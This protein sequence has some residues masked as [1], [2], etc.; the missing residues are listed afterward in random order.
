M[1]KS[2]KAEEVIFPGV[3]DIALNHVVVR[4]SKLSTAMILFSKLGYRH[5]GHDMFK[6]P[7]YKS[8]IF[9]AKYG[10]PHV[11][12]V[13]RPTPL[14]ASDESRLVMSVDNP[15]EVVNA[16]FNWSASRG[17]FADVVESTGGGY[18]I[19]LNTLLAMPL[20]FIPYNLISGS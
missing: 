6:K 3:G 15:G 20:E 19:T 8:I 18:I 12:L 13:F 7:S 16:I 5:S 4:V 10:C 1:V 9:M 11:H 2:L 17:L 14:P